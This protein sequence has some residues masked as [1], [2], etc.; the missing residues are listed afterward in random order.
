M[1]SFMSSWE[2]IHFLSPNRLIMCKKNL[3]NNNQTHDSCSDI[4]YLGDYQLRTKKGNFK[5]FSQINYK[6]RR[7]IGET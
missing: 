6:F 5:I 2:M 3:I 4:I 7:Q 1:G